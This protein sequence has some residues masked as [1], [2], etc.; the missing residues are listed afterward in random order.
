MT[1]RKLLPT[2]ALGIFLGALDMN[3]LA[4]ALQR[5]SEAFDISQAAAVWVV[6]AYSAAYMVAMPIVGRLGDLFGRKRAFVGGIMAF[7]LGSAACAASGWVGNWLWLLLAGR[8]VQGLGAGGLVPVATALIG[9]HVE[10]D[11]RGKALGVVGMCFG[12]ASILGPILGGVLL[13]R[14]GWEWLFAVNLPVGAVALVMALKHL[15]AGTRHD[16]GRVDWLGGLLLAVALGGFILGAEGLSTNLKELMPPFYGWVPQAWGAA[17]LALI[18]FLGWELKT[19]S[20][21]LDLGLYRSGPVRTAFALAF[22]YGAGMLI[23]MVFTPMYFHY[24]FQ[25]TSLQAGLGLL[26]MA[27][28]VGFSS[29]KGGKLSDKRGPRW[30][31]MLGLT[32]FAAGLGGLALWA[33]SAPVVAILGLLVV[34]GLGFGFCQAPLT[35]AVLSATDPAQHGQASGAVNTHRSLGGIVGATIGA[36]FIADAMSRIGTRMLDTLGDALPPTCIIPRVVDPNHVTE[37]VKL[38]PV[39]VRQRAI[40]TANRIVGEQMVD[41]LTALYTL[42]AGALV[43]ALMLAFW[44]PRRTPAMLEATVPAA[45]EAAPKA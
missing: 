42:G 5:L 13:D 35:H 7:T 9:E 28:A 25:F 45:P 38:L 18:G 33:A 29:M 11:R 44:L 4:L 14:I 16:G 8:A 22:L 34:T 2:L 17:A 31:L 27:L 36:F 40:D 23:A 41:G 19:A 26:P 6:V 43:M 24:R 20:P 21:M 15:P 1:P 10:P 32:C 30:V 12:G 39:E 3:I 37:M